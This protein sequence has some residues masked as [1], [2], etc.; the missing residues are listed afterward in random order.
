MKSYF[1][2]TLDYNKFGVT[3]CEL[4]HHFQADTLKQLNDVIYEAEYPYLETG[5]MIEYDYDTKK[6]RSIIEMVQSLY[7]EWPVES[8]YHLPEIVAMTFGIA[9]GVDHTWFD[10]HEELFFAI[11]LPETTK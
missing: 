2:I 10:P 1:A 6:F 9:I 3:K 11:T 7:V 5:A 8:E 4:T